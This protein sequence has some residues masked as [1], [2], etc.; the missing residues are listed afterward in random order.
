MEPGQMPIGRIPLTNKQEGRC[1]QVETVCVRPHIIRHRSLPDN[2]V[3]LE[4]ES[5]QR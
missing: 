5:T 1:I 2:L 4:F 3:A